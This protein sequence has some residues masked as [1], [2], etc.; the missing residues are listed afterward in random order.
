MVAFAAHTKY[1]I[2]MGNT[3]VTHKHRM[4]I[5]KTLTMISKVVLI[6]QSHMHIYDGVLCSC[7]LMQETELLMSTSRIVKYYVKGQLY[8]KLL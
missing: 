8:R 5:H 4:V 6:V 1:N 7:N 2:I 3:I